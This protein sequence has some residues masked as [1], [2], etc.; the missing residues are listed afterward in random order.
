MSSE[1][2][3]PLE[4]LFSQPQIYAFNGAVNGMEQVNVLA[5]VKATYHLTQSFRLA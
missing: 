4:K 5:E 1:F 3:P 2:K